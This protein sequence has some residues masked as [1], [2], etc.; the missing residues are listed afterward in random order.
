MLADGVGGK[1]SDSAVA[2]LFLGIVNFLL[3]MEPP[4]MVEPEQSRRLP[5]SSITVAVCR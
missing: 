3:E 1:G 2:V 5:Y 4:R